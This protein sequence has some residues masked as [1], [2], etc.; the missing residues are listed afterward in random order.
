MDSRA[1]QQEPSAGLCMDTV[2]P[3]I[4][5]GGEPGDTLLSMHWIQ[6]RKRACQVLWRSSNSPPPLLPLPPERCPTPPAV[7]KSIFCACTV[8]GSMF[9]GPSSPRWGPATLES[10]L[11]CIPLISVLHD[12]VSASLCNCVHN[13]A[14]YSLS[15][16]RS[17]EAHNSRWF[18]C[19]VSLM[20]H[21]SLPQQSISVW[22]H[23]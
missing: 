22:M 23:H 7:Q 8:N 13:C 14:N 16:G 4:S 19:L 17:V 1:A 2:L 9:S 10:A 20:L 12:V 5:C 15:I 21:H 11:G 3:S 18:C 6:R